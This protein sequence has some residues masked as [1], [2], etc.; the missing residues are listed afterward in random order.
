VAIINKHDDC[1]HYLHP[2]SR[3]TLTQFCQTMLISARLLVLKRGGSSYLVQVFA[4]SYLPKAVAFYSSGYKKGYLR[5]NVASTLGGN[6][7]EASSLSAK[8][9][10]SAISRIS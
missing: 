4:H 7:R 1:L 5:R 9:A 6:G 3:T 8:Y 10:V 2:N